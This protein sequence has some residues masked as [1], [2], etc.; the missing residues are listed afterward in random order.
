MNLSRI[1]SRLLPLSSAAVAAAG[2]ATLLAAARDAEA[3]QPL[4]G[5]IIAPSPGPSAIPPPA[6]I[7]PMMPGMQPAPPPPPSQQ[8]PPVAAPK[9]K[10]KPKVA[11]RPREDAA[12]GEGEGAVK[13]PNATRISLLVNGEPITAYEI[14]QR[15]RLMALSSGGDIQ[16]RAQATMKQL[17]T[18]EAVNA[19][20]KQIVQDTINANQG[21][22]R[23][24]VI[25]IIQEK[26]KAYSLGLQKQ[27]V[28]SARSA[29]LPGMRTKAREEL[30]EE[31]IKLQDARRSGTTPDEGLVEDLVKDLAQRNKMSSAEFTRHFAGMGIDVATLKAKFRA[32]LAWTDAVRKQYGHLAQPSQRDLD[33]ALVNFSGGEDELE[34]QLRRIVLSV[35]AKVDQRAMT[36]RLA[37]AEQLQAQFKECRNMAALAAR[38]QGARFE[39]MGIRNPKAFPEPSK[40]L[41]SNAADNSMIPPTMSSSG[42]EL[43]AVCGRRVIKATEV[44]RS[45]LAQDERRA[46]FERLANGHLRRLK[47]NAIIENR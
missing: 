23:E 40:T 25:A 19:R 6:G 28:E 41:L 21:K 32:Q 20:W 31:Q 37:E 24:Q 18:S 26:Q 44:K 47:D 4:P 7:S 45:E 3:Q 46:A 1:R 35:P 9:P 17:A 5:I 36:Q 29:V 2:V 10:P 27:A 42:I 43:L 16:A 38:V 15:A 39:D 33:R 8:Q 13:G 30:I 22:S 14:E 11:A 12:A 34:L